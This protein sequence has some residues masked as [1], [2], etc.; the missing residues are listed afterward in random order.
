MR[1]P[2]GVGWE[3]GPGGVA[4]LV[5]GTERCHARLTP[6]GAQVCEWTPAGQQASALFL[7][8]RATF[9]VGTSI[10]GGIPVCFPWF[11]A[12]PSDPTKPAH[13]FARTRI[14]EVAE[15][16]RDG[17]GDVRAVLRLTSD[18]GTRA[19][20]PFEFAASLTVTLGPS[21]AMTFEVENTGA[22]EAAYES[23]LHTYL[24]VGDVETIRIHGLERTR[25]ID[26]V[27][28]MRETRSDAAPLTLA[29][30]I[31][32]VFLD[33]RAPC[34]VEDPVLQRRIRV[35]KSHSL[36]TVVWNPGAEKARAVSDIGDAWR[37]FV[38]V[39]TANC[40]PHAVRLAPR[41]RHAMTA[42]IDV[43][44]AALSPSAGRRAP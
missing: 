30:E 4:F 35:E 25:F 36:A 20:W 18:A 37:R 24:A 44:S 21:L 22:G 7:S 43:V 16:N 34:T 41:A 27:D 13:G 11:A 2:E 28:G 32:R 5:I 38:C 10:R 1:L 29:G 26:K 9:A 12:H 14:W 31:D 3:S 39:E 42:R 40:G 33:T 19:H 8:P 23:A 15:V 6:Y 17:A